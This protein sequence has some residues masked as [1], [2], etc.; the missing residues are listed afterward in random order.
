V[1]VMWPSSVLLVVCVVL[2]MSLGEGTESAASAQF[3]CNDR[4]CSSSEQLC[5]RPRSMC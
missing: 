4:V 3:P 1:C 2:V 5:L